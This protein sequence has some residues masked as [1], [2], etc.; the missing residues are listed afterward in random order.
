[1]TMRVADWIMWRLAQ[2]GLT[3]VFTLPGG[4]AMFLNDALAICPDLTPIPC[5]HEQAC[6]IA[7]EAYGRTHPAGFGVALVTTGPGATNVITPVAGA[8]IESLPLLVISGQ[9]KRAD[10]LAGKNLR[11]TGVQEVNIVPMVEPVTK[12]AQTL[13]EPKDVRIE[14]ERALHIMRQGR[15]GPV[16]LDIP[17]D[18]QAAPIDPADLAPYVPPMLDS[19]VQ[20]A[21]SASTSTLTKLLSHAQRPLILAGHGVRISGGADVF[22][23][24]VRHLNIPCVFTWNAMDLLPFD[25]A[26]YVGR[27]GTVA[28]RAPNFA[29]QSA[30]LLIV[31]GCRLDNVVTA[32][33]LDGFGR[34]AEKLVVDI[35]SNELSRLPYSPQH[36]ICG[37]VNA[38]MQTWL[39]ELPEHAHTPWQTWRQTC[40]SWK[41]RY[42]AH[43]GHP[44]ENSSP[45]NHYALMNILSEQLRADRVIATGS[46]GLAIEV[47]YTSFR[48]KPGQR[49]F[50]TSGLGA[51]GYGLASAVGTCI[52]T[53]RKA[54][55]CIESDG[56]LMLNLQELATIAAQMLP[57]TIVVMNNGGYASIRNTQTNY[58]ERRFI[59]VDADSGVSIPRLS[60]VARQ[61]GIEATTVDNHDDLIEVLSLDS[62][63]PRLIEV[64]LENTETLSPKCS[65]LPQ[66]DG[67]MLSMPLEDMSPLLSL[68]QLG[69]ELFAPP[70]EQ[71]ISARRFS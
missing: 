17:L 43:E 10:R 40:Q 18:V 9:V 52:G 22:R 8:W 2:E 59:G 34:H 69:A 36:L 16:W 20:P 55:Y 45:I 32:Y 29:I 47:F 37:D 5:Q 62:T 11:Q 7:A 6:G 51:M 50:L 71:S 41:V 70:S 65:A 38:V 67:S 25:D 49:I 23:Q 54:C 63:R 1:M 4:G 24:L 33:N 64:M 26:L 48:N 21:L 56:S 68:E 19:C 13:L 58:F 53:A 27:P 3:D 39:D 28:A 61:F 66:P 60:D 44:L 14:L 35:D 57:I 15:P 46:S 30:D 31:L 12:Y 42:P